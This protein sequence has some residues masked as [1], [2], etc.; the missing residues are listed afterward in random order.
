MEKRI[1]L[2]GFFWR[3][4]AVDA[5][6]A[7][8]VCMLPWVHVAQP[9]VVQLNPMLLLLL[10][11]M[12]LV[13][14][15]RNAFLLAVLLPVVSAALVGMPTPARAFCM[16]AELSTVVAVYG[17]LGTRVKRFWGLLAGMVAGK[18]VYYGLKA[19]L[20]SPAALIGTS[21]GVQVAVMVLAAGLFAF[22][23]RKKQ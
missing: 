14:G 7:G 5:A 23:Q 9:W 17:L 10:T 12:L 21:V 11:G 8:A 13:P 19:L 20:L 6:L 18:A 1:V 2:T 4:L 22:L 15:R 16:V 3:A